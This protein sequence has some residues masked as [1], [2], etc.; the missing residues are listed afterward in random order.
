MTD[1]APESPLVLRE[2]SDG[3]ATLTLNRP[4]K[5]NALSISML[6][7]LQGV[8][9]AV[10]DDKSIRAV[11]IAANGPAFC[12]GHDL[13]EIRANPGRQNYDALFTLCS[14]VMRAI[15]HLPQP[16]IARVHALATAAGCQLVA[17]CDLAVAAKSAW[18]ATP[19]VHIG[20]FCS[21]PMVPLSRNIGRKQAMQMLVTGDRIDAETAERWGLINQAVEDDLL[22]KAVAE[23]TAKITSKSPL[24]L[25]IGKEA[26]YRQLE[27]D[28]DTAYAYVTETMTVNLMS[29]DAE[30]GIDAFLEKR[31]PQWLGK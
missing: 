17:S 8:L 15:T 27:M 22:D 1:Q 25:K 12:S 29:Y 13:K 21:T 6:E 28:I 16:V 11:V 7:T 23:L 9:S 2:D 19:G 5:R 26:F 10:T 18:F 4:D 31:K 24:T 3:V 14:D 30:E 20:L